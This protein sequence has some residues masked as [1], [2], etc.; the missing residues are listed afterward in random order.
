MVEV[1]LVDP[2]ASGSPSLHLCDHR[3]ALPSRALDVG[4]EGVSLGLF[5]C[6]EVAVAY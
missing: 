2:L 3:C 6:A 4:P 5:A 1:S